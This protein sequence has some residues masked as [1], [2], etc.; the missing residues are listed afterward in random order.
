[1]R[2]LKK[3][4]SLVLALVFGLGLCTVG[5]NAAF[6][7]YSDLDKVTTEYEDAVEVLSGL[8]IIDGYPDGTFGPEK[9]VTRAEAAAMIARMML[10]RDAADKLPVGEVKF[11]DVAEDSWAAKYIAFCANKGII[12]GMGDGT[13]HPADNITG[14]QMAAMLLRA[15]GYD[16]MGEY[17]GKGWDINAVADA[18]YYGVFKDSKAADFNK[19]A[20][21][22]ETALYIWNT[23]WITLVGYDV[24]RNYY[25]E[26][27][28]YSDGKW[29]E[30][31]FANDAFNLEEIGYKSKTD[32]HTV[33]LL[34]N[35]ASGSKYTVV[36][37]WDT[38]SR[39]DLTLVEL[40]LNYEFPEEEAKDWIGHEVTVYI[41]A[42]AQQDKTDNSYFYNCYLVKKE[43]SVLEKGKTMDD[44]YR[45]AKAANKNNVSKEFGDI[46]Q[47]MNYDPYNWSFVSDVTDSDDATTYTT[48]ADLKGQK[49]SNDSAPGGT[50]IIDHAGEILLVLSTGHKV[51]RVRAVDDDHDEVELEVY[52]GDT[53][54]EI[55]PY[56]WEDVELVYDGIAKDDYVIIEPVGELYYVGPTTTETVDISNIWP[57]KMM[58][59][60][61]PGFTID[62]VYY[63]FNNYSQSPDFSGLGI[64]I[65]DQDDPEEV[66][67]GDN[68]KFYK[69]AKYG[70][71]G[72][73]ILEKA[74][75][76]GIVYI[77]YVDVFI[78]HGEWDTIS[79]KDG[80]DTDTAKLN[81]V[82][83]FQ[84]INESG[85]EVVY[86]FTK[87]KA[88]E[89]F[90]VDITDEAAVKALA[91]K[92]EGTAVE[93]RKTGKSFIFVD[94]PKNVVTLHTD[95]KKTSY[96]TKD[97]NTYYV[98]S[99]TTAVYFT[100]K[101]PDL[102]IDLASKL[103]KAAEGY[104]VVAV[105]KKSG[106]SFKIST[107][108]VKDQEAPEDFGSSFLYV[109]PKITYSATKDSS[110]NVYD[111]LVKY[112]GEIYGYELFNGESDPYYMV[113]IDGQYSKVHVTTDYAGIIGRDGTLTN[114]FYQFYIN[115]DGVYELKKAEKVNMGQWLRK[116][117]V[118]N[119]RFYLDGHSDGVDLNVTILDISGDTT[120][121]TR[122]DATVMSL[123]RME[124][125]LSEGYEMKVDYKFVTT[126]EN[127]IIDE[128]P[129]GVMYITKIV[130]PERPSN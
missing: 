3:S 104:D 34:A 39:G 109:S 45:A 118:K 70:Y 124:E 123:D 32:K 49:S 99:D 6:A 122:T 127:G 41:E 74:K 26:K 25:D 1:M 10:G 2:T 54:P 65:E 5:S 12:V 21:R 60:I 64:Y 55:Y 43:S 78:D 51:A 102:E 120:S 77:N 38:N 96:L 130:A 47:W 17:Q 128:I 81:T 24:D 92:Y 46:Q 9:N 66:G 91:D 16:A 13:F 73:Q 95:G 4:L 31:T 8:M 27:E 88:Q 30:L 58:I 37:Y 117:N 69:S 56:A 44:F 97:G 80:D 62:M 108:W 15:L 106:G 83:K 53:Y 18:L 103:A 33:V 129:V 68:V 48:I 22:E 67:V 20:T 57:F 50:W 100:G 36:G 82:L 111:M 101:G 76:E 79:N 114:Y 89:A 42:E 29:V 19:P 115:D 52:N 107:A 7:G 35:K 14:T 11:T 72:L 94:E 98:T 90:G 126:E 75:S 84:G 63:Y 125:L 86:K 119:D 40:N 121:R 28:R 71:F 23:L 116:G 112:S 87:K 113:F 93:V 59:Q 85:E 110:G 61:V 105:A